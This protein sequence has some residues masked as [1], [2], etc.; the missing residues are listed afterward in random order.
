[1]FVS[2]LERFDLFVTLVARGFFLGDGLL[3]RTGIGEIKN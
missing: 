3:C 2:H 1:M